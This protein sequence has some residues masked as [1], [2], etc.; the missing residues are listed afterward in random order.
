MMIEE[1]EE[2]K[3]ATVVTIAWAIWTNRNEVRHGWT[4]KPGEALV[5][6]STQYLAEYNCANSSSVQIQRSQIVRWSPPPPARYKMNLDGAVF[7]AQKVVGIGVLIRDA[8][9]RVVVALSQKLN[10]P[11]GALE[12]EAKAVEVALQFARDVGISNFIMEGDSL[13][14]YNA[15]CGHSFPPSLVATIISGAIGFCGLF[16]WVEFSHIHR[17]GNKPAH[18]L[19]KHAKGIDDYVA[20]LE[21]TPCFL[22]QHF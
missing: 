12:V 9:G 4:K 15:L 16:H 2:D 7:K 8:Q 14:V 21:E 19:A 11:L 22:M 13:I 20:W 10:A 1:C 3:L 6:W 18:I 5:K 17:Q